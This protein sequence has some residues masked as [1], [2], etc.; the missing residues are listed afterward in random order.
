MNK[1]IYYYQTF[2]GL[3]GILNQNPTPV[4][5]III[6]SIHF[7]TNLD[8]SPYIHL[9]DNLPYDKCFDDMWS[10]ALM[11][12]EKGIN[13]H[14]MLG[15]AGGAFIDLFS[16]F[17]IYYRLLIELIKEKDFINGINL[18][19]EESIG[20]D[21]TITLIKKLRED[22]GDEFTISLAPVSFALVSNGQGLGGFSYADLIN[23]E[24]GTEL[25]FLNGQFY[26]DFTFETYD[27]A[28]EN[29]YEPEELVIGMLGTE[30]N[31]NT[32][33]EACNEI[34][35]IYSKYPEFG[36]VFLW[37]YCDAPTGG[38]SPEKWALEISKAIKKEKFKRDV[39]VFFENIKDCFVKLGD[40]IRDLCMGISHI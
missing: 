6:S 25:D 15:G 30:Y 9:N 35:K 36:G 37:E 28:I 31:N 20:L 26:G 8:G 24:V 4:T 33:Q 32:L 14:L 34:R 40:Q 38:N 22:L 39:I 12:Y 18:D 13:I 11:A 19:I 5:D 7:G 3:E 27:K 29:G 17:D 16:N 2:I 23:S 10:E 21:N 1:I